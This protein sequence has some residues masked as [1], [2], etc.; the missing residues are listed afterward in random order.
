[1]PIVLSDPLQADVP[2]M[3][4]EIELWLS[5]ILSKL[6][7]LGMLWSIFIHAWRD[8]KRHG[9]LWEDFLTLCMARTCEE[10][11]KKDVVFSYKKLF[12]R[13]HQARLKSSMQGAIT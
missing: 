12:V 3:T 5:V 8:S 2:H 9:C 13:P 11:F 7:K 10:S 4:T 1:M 6:L